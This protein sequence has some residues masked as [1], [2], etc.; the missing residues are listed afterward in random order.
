VIAVAFTPPVSATHVHDDAGLYDNAGICGP[1]G[2]LPYCRQHW[3]VTQSGLGTCP[4]G[5]GKSLD[6]H[7][8][9]DDW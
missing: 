7:W 2:D 5:H 1:C 4:H 6:S 8:S 3:H 9:P